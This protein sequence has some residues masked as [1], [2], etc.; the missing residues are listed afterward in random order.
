MI[1]KET[2]ENGATKLLDIV[3]GIKISGKKMKELD[4]IEYEQ[5]VLKSI[6]SNIYTKFEVFVRDTLINLCDTIKEYEYIDG[7]LLSDS[8]KSKYLKD[9]VSRVKNGNNINES[10]YE[11]ALNIEEIKMLYFAQRGLYRIKQCEIDFTQLPHS[12]GEL[13]KLFGMYLNENNMLYNL[14]LDDNTSEDLSGVETHKTISAYA[15]LNRFIEKVRHPIVHRDEY[16]ENLT[17]EYVIRSINNFLTIV[18]EISDKSK[19]YL[20][21][22]DCGMKSFNLNDFMKDIV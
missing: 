19:N 2:F 9:T 6:L 14:Y 7:R 17:T 22:I 20:K 10:N 11:Q 5:F 12:M 16:L 3:K 13:N 4:Y 21:F 15:F 1:M 8:L 18:S